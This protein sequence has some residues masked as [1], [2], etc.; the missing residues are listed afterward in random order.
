MVADRR[1][2]DAR[3]HRDAPG[4]RTKLGLI[5]ARATIGGKP[6]AYTRLRS[7]YMHE[8]DSAIGFSDF[9]DPNFVHDAKSFQQAASHIGYTFNWFYVDDKHIA[10]FNSGNNPVRAPRTDGQLPIRGLPQ[11]EWRNF[12][13]DAVTADY[14]PFAQHPQVVNQD[15]LTSWNNK[16]APLF[17]GDAPN[18]YG[19]LY[20]SQLLDDQIN[21]R[22]K[23]G[24]KLTLPGLVDSM[25]EAATVDLRGWRVLQWALRV[26]GTPSDPKLA[27]AVA[28]LAA[29][30]ASGAHRRDHDHNGVYDDAEAVRIMD[31][32]WP[33][34][35]KAEFEPR[36][37]PE[38]FDRLKQ[39]YEFSNDPNNHGDHLGSAWQTGWYG[40]AQKDLR[41][42]L[43]KR[44]RGAYARRF[45]GFG[46]IKRCRAALLSSLADALAHDSAQELY[47]NDPV[48]SSKEGAGLD[49]QWCFDAVRFRP[50]G[51][52][53]QPLIHWVNRPTYQQAVEL[54]GH[55]PR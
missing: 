5:V 32:W 15:V 28:K 30:R 43:K 29:W 50:L 33:R 55:R 17:A 31:A 36:L 12:N 2:L 39:S 38:L 27:D 21:H 49:P 14:T 35:L 48:C 25:E 47:G 41:T 53:T 54:T 20:R 51:G 9:N 8:A 1:R 3:G 4:E 10:Y 44:V 6:V 26:I 52:A 22:L 24:A 16:Q 19:T 18:V 23:G 7:T 46:G 34:W 45:C 37:G 40:F 42:V 11:Y 13:P